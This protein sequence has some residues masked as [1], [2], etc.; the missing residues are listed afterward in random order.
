MV[1]SGVILAVGAKWLIEKLHAIPDTI[2][3]QGKI[4]VE[5]RYNLWVGITIKVEWNK[6]GKFY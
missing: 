2:L 5:A 6:K 1:R 3:E 4:I